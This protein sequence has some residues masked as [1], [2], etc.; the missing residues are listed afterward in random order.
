M[1][2]MLM[3]NTMRD[4][5][6]TKARFISI[7]L[8]IMLSVGFLVG[9]NSVS[10]SMMAVAKE[11]YAQQNLMDFRLISTVGFTQEDVSAVA[12]IDGVKD[13]M[14]SYFM[15]VLP[16]GETG[17]V[18]RLYAL[19]ESYED[20]GVINEITLREGRLPQADNEIVIGSGGLGEFDIGSKISFTS[21]VKDDDLSDT[22]K[23]TE[24]E[25]VGIIDSPMYISF[26]RGST[27]VGS[28]K[29]AAYMMIPKGNFLMERYT[30][31]YVTFSALYGVSPYSQEYN[32]IRD[33]IKKTLEGV[34]DVRIEAFNNEEIVSAQASIDEAKTTLSDER[35]KADDEIEKAQKQI[36][37]G[38]ETLYSEESRTRN[39]LASAKSQID[40]G[41]AE[42]ESN[43]TLFNNTIS[44]AK[45]EIEKNEEELS[46]GEKS[47]TE[48]KSTLKET[49]FDSI[50]KLGVTR[51][52]YES[53]YAGRDMLSKED[54]ELIA[55]LAQ[56]YR[57][58]I[59]SSLASSQTALATL[60]AELT[61]AG[62]DPMANPEYLALKQQCDTLSDA[63]VSVDTFLATGKDELISTI[64]TITSQ[65]ETIKKG[66]EDL[67]S[68][69]TTL[70]EQ[71]AQ[72]LAA[73][74]QAEADISKAQAQYD[75]GVAQL[76]STV[77]STKEKLQSAQEELDGKKSEAD[78]EFLKAE[79]EISDAQSTLDSIP[80]P[81]W[82]CHTRSNNPGYDA[83]VDDVG[84]VAAVGKVFPV[85]FMLVAILVCVTTMSRLVEEQRGDI[86]AL[87]TLGYRRKDI[88]A[89]YII[90][91]L[92]ATVLGSALGIVWGLP[93]IPYVIYNAYRMLYSSMPALILTMSTGSAV[94][95]ILVAMLCTSSVALLTCYSLLCK[96][97]A[98]LLRP[99]APKPGK[100]IFLEKVKFIWNRLGFF[101]KVT[102]RNI[103]RYKARFF[104]TVI[105]VAGCT[106]LVFAAL[107]LYSSINDV[108][109]KQF[110]EIF[111]YD[112]VVALEDSSKA[113]DVK[114][115]LSADERIEDVSLCRQNLAAVMGPWGKYTDD[116]YIYVPESVDEFKKIVDLHERRSGEKIE[117]GESGVVLT[118]K[119][120][121]NLKLS[122]GDTVKVEDKGVRAELTV[123]GICENY[124]YGYA[125]MSPKV[126]EENFGFAPE[127]NM[128]MCTETAKGKVAHSEMGEAFLKEEGV[129]GVSFIED[130]TATFYE[131]IGSLDY[132]VLVML[133]CA[134]ALAFVVLYNLTNINIAERK[135]EIST[136]KVL[137]FKNTETSAYIYRENLVL[138]LVGASGGLVL[139]IWFL[140]FI[141]KTVEID[142]LMFGREMHFMSF[143]I[144]FVLTVVFSVIVNFVMHLRIKKIDMI[145][146]LK[147]VE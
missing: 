123:S 35:E 78:G 121:G 22:L 91:S 68:A 33:T 100:R 120:A 34:A 36:D 97:P 24:F 1:N 101:S 62:Q 140:K 124:L 4:I 63:L 110:G 108:V 67:E 60:E 128:F 70:D 20:Y 99:K 6:K 92:S 90:Y 82:L 95:A 15:D 146:S 89:K 79:G 29:V 141:I 84:R 9:I 56:M 105:G 58:K 107:G 41:K 23:Y 7:M 66:R 51:E 44:D 12:E 59:A 21:P 83:Y 54:I 57:G 47:I 88:I 117:I 53:F 52:Q 125:Y 3:K 81:E 65:E 119:L 93:S 31:L 80:T 25:I 85:F 116:T 38:Y 73:I 102:V 122:V 2:K 111:N 61:S 127:Y 16:V 8:I 42:L 28:G 55:G 118:E 133:V 14:P 37:D 103:F 136:L 64:D 69:K 145:E 75:S 134:G 39:T 104:M 137:G 109:S 49:L 143:V 11:Y 18:V 96:N 131:M 114:G 77:A 5:R 135:R 19:P 40:S 87:T 130:N 147:S 113:Q 139:G 10:P 144:A 43:K 126:Y 98:T 138:T 76:E 48:A 132:V 13:V 71:Q 112:V 94:V 129:L 26:E 30:D 142:M 115:L 27:N 50:S 17:N 45:A 86:G 72:G 46:A 106:A 32:T 74:S